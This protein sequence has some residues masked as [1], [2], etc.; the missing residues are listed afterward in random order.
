MCAEIVAEDDP[1]IEDCLDAIEF[2][3]AAGTAAWAGADDPTHEDFDRAIAD[4]RGYSRALEVSSAF[5]RA[6]LSGDDSDESTDPIQTWFRI[7]R[8]ERTL[9]TCFIGESVSVSTAEC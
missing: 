4:V 7:G 6:Q 1:V 9:W 5:R 2:E 3:L 8:F